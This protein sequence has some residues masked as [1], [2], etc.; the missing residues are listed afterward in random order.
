MIRLYDKHMLNVYPRVENSRSQSVDLNNGHLAYCRGFSVYRQYAQPGLQTREEDY[1]AS[2]ALGVSAAYE[3]FK[4]R[5][6]ERVVSWSDSGV[7]YSV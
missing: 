2:S 7:D 5:V 1:A 3:I 6:R 4:E